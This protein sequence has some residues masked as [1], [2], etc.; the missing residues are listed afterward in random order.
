MEQAT[1]N[2]A[3]KLAASLQEA[4]H[5][6]LAKVVARGIGVEYASTLPVI[7]TRARPPTIADAH[8]EIADFHAK[9]ALRHYHAI[10]NIKDKYPN[11]RPRGVKVLLEHHN[12]EL[13]HHNKLADFHDNILLHS[14]QK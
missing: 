14:W 2:K 4:G 11:A 7:P 13:S 1:I 3:K 10:N 5:K 12:T 9:Q 6:E 8:S